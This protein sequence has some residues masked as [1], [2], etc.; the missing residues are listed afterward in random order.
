[1]SKS[2]VYLVSSTPVDADRGTKPGYDSTSVDAHKRNH[3]VYDNSVF[4][5]SEEK[6]T[7][8]E[9][10]GSVLEFEKVRPSKPY[11][12]MGKEDLLYFSSQPFWRRLRMICVAIVLIGWVALIITVAALVLAYPR[13]REAPSRSWWQAEAVYRVY[14]PSF[15]D[16][17][18]DGIGDLKGIESKLDYIK[19]Q[20]FGV[21]SLSPIYAT[22]NTESNPTINAFRAGNDLAVT[23]HKAVGGVYGTLGDIDSLVAAV[24]DRGMYLVL[25]FIPGVTG[26]THAWFSESRNN[27]SERRNFYVW[28]GKASD[29]D[30]PNNWKSHFGIPAW[31]KDSTRQQFYLHQFASDTP[32][33]NLRSAAVREELEDILTFWLDRD[34]DGFN[35]RDPGF[36]F[37][38]F[39]LRNNT[40]KPGITSPGNA[41][42]DYDPI[43]TSGQPE[44]YGLLEEWR[45][46]LRAHNKTAT[47]KV[48]LTNVDGAL[49]ISRIYSFCDRSGV[50]MP[51]NTG[52]L[53]TTSCNGACV[54]KLVSDWMGKTP[55]GKWATWMSGGDNYDRIFTTFNASYVEAFMTLS[56]L[57]PGTPV[58]YYGDEIGAQ[59]IGSG[60]AM[61]AARNGTSRGIMT[62]NANSTQDGFCD[63]CTNIWTS[64]MSRAEQQ[65]GPTSDYIK[66]LVTLRRKVSFK[67]GEYSRAL[68]DDDVF[69]FVR[70][71]DGEPGYLVAIN[72]GPNKVSRDFIGSHD[73]ISPEGVI[74]MTRGTAYSVDDKVNPAKLEIEAYGAVVVSWDYVAKEL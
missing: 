14:V 72:F 24:H 47:E 16:S 8:S 17:N 58:L 46:T 3:Q 15:K 38:D 12:G 50:Q 73:T 18:G 74:A 19:D 10:N 56:F 31:T 57:L 48:L 71:V 26:T 22:A 11:R 13:C 65:R 43:H 21:I 42:T 54:T 37:E 51:L 64:V 70:E 23:D 27:G 5:N 49:D 40:V 36:I 67:S 29:A 63:N 45:M 20:G 62:W 2:G 28:A 4:T 30:P 55:S 1:M 41:Y 35:I 6:V 9:A 7:Y 25:D 69:S 53:T 59:N 39:D 60:S 33:L 66:E 61:T 34:I 44:V 68:V 52:F 32:D